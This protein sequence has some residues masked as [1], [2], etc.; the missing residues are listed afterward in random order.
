MSEN[1]V[2]RHLRELRE[3]LTPPPGLD[4]PEISDGQ[5]VMMM[6]PRPRHQ[7][8]AKRVTRQ[9]DQQLPDGIFAYE[10]TDTDDELLG[11]LRVPDVLVVSEEAMLAAEPTL[12]P[13]EIL[14][15]VEIVSPSNP[16]NDYRDKLA[17][18]PRMGIPRYLIVDPRE[19]TWSYH[20]DIVTNGGVPAY[21]SRLGKRPFGDA[22]T[23]DTEVGRWTIET[24]GLPLYTETDMA[25]G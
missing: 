4:Y 6:S 22:V 12:D 15:A 3:H 20:W 14:L 25:L 8:N 23:I 24:V 10:S 13:R 2:Y 17:D 11:K 19:G 21:A 18:Y 5:L 9:L 16:D 1:T 7:V